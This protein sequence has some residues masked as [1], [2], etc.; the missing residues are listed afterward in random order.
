MR[1]AAG[2]DV[3]GQNGRGFFGVAKIW[4]NLLGQIGHRCS[5]LLCC[6]KNQKDPLCGSSF[7]GTRLSVSVFHFIRIIFSSLSFFGIGINFVDNFVV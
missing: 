5:F 1:R 4:M 6:L 7:L 3:D 2:C